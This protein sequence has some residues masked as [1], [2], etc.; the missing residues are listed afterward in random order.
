M[1]AHIVYN[2]ISKEQEH[3]NRKDGTHY[4]ADNQIAGNT[5]KADREGSQGLTDR[6]HDQV[7]L[8]IHKR[9]RRADPEQDRQDNNRDAQKQHGQHRKTQE[10]GSR[11]ARSNSINNQKPSAAAI[12]RRKAGER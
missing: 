9:S 10:N 4:G 1:C 11:Q 3:R 8:R 7:E 6:R 5:H 12:P 2:I